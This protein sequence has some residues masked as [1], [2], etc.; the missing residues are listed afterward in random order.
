MSVFL[1]AIGSISFVFGVN[2]KPP[3]R[4]PLA[5]IVSLTLFVV[6]ANA[7]VFLDVIVRVVT[8][9]GNRCVRVCVCVCEMVASFVLNT[10][11]Q[12]R[13]IFLR[14]LQSCLV[15]G[16]LVFCNVRRLLCLLKLCWQSASRE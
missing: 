2:L 11:F 3:H 15:G 7:V 1:V 10:R 4:G 5:A 13:L 14:K 12:V 16:L 6:L 8:F 9:G